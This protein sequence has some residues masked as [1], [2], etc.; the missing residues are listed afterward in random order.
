MGLLLQEYNFEVV[1]RANITNLDVDGL[2][3]NPSP[4]DEDLI[5]ATWNEDCDQEAVSGWHIVAYLILFFGFA[6]EVPIQG[7][8][9]EID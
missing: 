6:A 7:L 9:N 5:G 2:S 4:S 3:R 8:D 1:H